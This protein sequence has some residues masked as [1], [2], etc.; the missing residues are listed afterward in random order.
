MGIASLGGLLSGSGDV[1][2]PNR[3]QIGQQYRGLFNT[4][5][6]SAGP[7][8]NTEAQYKP[9]FTEQNLGNLDLTLNGADGVPGLISLLTGAQSA[10]RSAN[11]QD[12]NTLNPQAAALMGQLNDQASSGLAAGGQLA[13]NDIYRIT[14][15][16]RGDWAN[17]GLGASS[18]AQFDEA[19][20]LATAG[21]GLRQ[22]RQGFAQGVA[23]LNQNQFN[24]FDNQL[25]PASALAF[26]QGAGPTLFDT[27]QAG[28]LLQ[29]VFGEGNANARSTSANNTGLYQS[30]DANQSSFISSL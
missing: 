5:L 22:S 17:R 3:R 20:N 15:G 19:L 16:V 29:S 8:L 2:A 12:F 7:L 28:S 13:P 25:L 26:S 27:G 18:P 9:Q 30:M 11:Q 21:E 6:G 14:Q 10:G 4:F 24:S 23:G 1:N